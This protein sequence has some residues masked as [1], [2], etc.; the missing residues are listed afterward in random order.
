MEYTVLLN[1]TAIHGVPAA[2]N[3][4]NTALLRAF[5]GDV[6]A[7]IRAVNHPLPT[8]R[9]EDAVKVEQMSGVQPFFLLNSSDMQSCFCLYTQKKGLR[10]GLG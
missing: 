6:N 10:D 1:Q 8:V 3:A 9:N 2:L 4:A 7:S 5:T